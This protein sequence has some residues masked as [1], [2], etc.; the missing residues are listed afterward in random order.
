MKEVVS[1]IMSL[2]KPISIGAVVGVILI[3]VYSKTNG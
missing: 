2:W 3:I 1:D